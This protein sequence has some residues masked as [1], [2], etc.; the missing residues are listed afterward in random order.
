MNNVVIQTNSEEQTGDFARQCANNAQIGD[1]FLLNGP[2]GAGKSVFARA[3]IQHLVGSDVEVPSPTFTLLQTYSTPKSPL[4][5]FD[6]YRL[7]DPEEIYEL[8]WEDAIQN[9]ILL[10][11]WPTKLGHLK[12]KNYKEINIKPTDDTSRKITLNQITDE[13]NDK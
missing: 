10:I 12:P 13:N 3:F 2:L 7:E 11:E 4:W 5:H 8:G 6:L 9:H 1:V